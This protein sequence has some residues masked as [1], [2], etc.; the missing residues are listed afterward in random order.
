MLEERHHF[1]KPIFLGIA[2]FI[3]W[4]LLF[5]YRT[6]F[7]W[8]DGTIYSSLFDDAMISMR[9]AWNLA[10][11]NG[12]VWN[13]GEYVQGYSNL[14]MTLLM[15]AVHVVAS[16]RIA[17][18][19]VQLLGISFVLTG[20]LLSM[21]I[22]KNLAAGAEA[23]NGNAVA[24]LSFIMVLCY[25]PLSYWSL[26]G[27]ETG[28][29]T[30]CL[31]AATLWLLRF[32]NTGCPRRLYLCLLFM[33]LAFTT[34]SE[35]AIFCGIMGAYALY[36]IMKYKHGHSLGNWF[37]AALIYALSVGCILLFQHGYYGEYLPNTYTLKLTGKDLGERIVDGIA[38]IRPH[39]LAILFT[40]TVVTIGTLR[41]ATDKKLLLLTLLAGGVAY[42][43]YIG[44][45]AWPYWRIT[46]PVMPFL[47]ILF[48]VTVSGWKQ[49][50]LPCVAT[51]MTK[52][53]TPRMNSLLRT[54]CVMTALFSVNYHFLP[55][56][57]MTAKP[58]HAEYD[59]QR[60]KTG[61]AL[62]EI[63]TEDATV[64][65]FSAGAIPY[66]SKRRAVDFL[67]KSDRIIAKL[68]PDRSSIM[69][70]YGMRSLPGHDKYDIEYSVGQHLPSYIEGATWGQQT[71]SRGLL[72]QYAAVSYKGMPLLLRANDP[73]VL[74][75]LL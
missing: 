67:G 32:Q 57:S 31:L 22:G 30:V 47:L 50:L 17:V 41:K 46:T 37:L 48:A 19:I 10:N 43:I 62:A 13:E 9:Y 7:T 55:E 14:L 71:L 6:S 25:Y 23:N 3:V 38:F 15:A 66:Y 72:L 70:M 35:S 65:V 59:A 26:M 56:I 29:L 69:A 34:R 45:D 18:F 1:R 60:A 28:L 11:G 5:I 68:P 44:G 4:S 12:L 54:S 53:D 73:N 21:Q 16:D 24:L 51:S 20:G 64:G 39:L 63:T 58:F 52:I 8:Y 2:A 75:E 49:S 40:V 33:V 74:W 36:V 42:H 61:L 27:M